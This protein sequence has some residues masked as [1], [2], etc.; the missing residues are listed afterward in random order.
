MGRREPE[1]TGQ[2]QGTF[3]GGAAILAV[4]ILVVKLIGMFYKIPLVNMIKIGKN[5]VRGMK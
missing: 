3:F 2:K 5:A 4:G 1:R